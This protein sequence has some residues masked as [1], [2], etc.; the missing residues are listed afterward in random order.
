MSSKHRLSYGF[1]KKHFQGFQGD[2]NYSKEKN[3]MKFKKT[4]WYYCGRGETRVWY[5]K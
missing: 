4:S 3:P 2:K 5:E 1:Q